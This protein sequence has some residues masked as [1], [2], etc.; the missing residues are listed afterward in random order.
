MSIFQTLNRLGILSVGRRPEWQRQ[1]VTAG[2][3]ASPSA[4]VALSGAVKTLVFVSLREDPRYHVAKI[5]ITTFDAATDYTITVDG[6]SYTETGDTAPEVTLEALAAAIGFERA[7]AM[8]DT[9]TVRADESV[10]VSASGGAG[11]IEIVSQEATS[12]TARVWLYASGPG[13]WVLANEGAFDV[14]AGGIT[15]RLSTAGFDRLY[16]E[17]ETDGEVTVYVGPGVME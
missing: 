2:P 3:P 1:L 14:E 6:A 4:G 10:S 12:A 13:R 8:E 17:V 15:E 16:V 5:K 7:E 11:E 9:L